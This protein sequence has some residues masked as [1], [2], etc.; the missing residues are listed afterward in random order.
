[1]PCSR[2]RVSRMSNV[3]PSMT[4]ARPVMGSAA[5]AGPAH[6]RTAAVKS[7]IGQPSIRH[8]R[9][10]RVGGQ[11]GSHK[12]SCHRAQPA[13]VCRRAARM[14]HLVA[15]T[16]RLVMGSA[17]YAGRHRIGRATPPTCRTT[18]ARNPGPR[19]TQDRIAILGRATAA[20]AR[21]DRTRP[22]A[23]L[24]PIGTEAASRRC[25]EERGEHPQCEIR[26]TIAEPVNGPSGTCS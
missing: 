2:T 3:S 26:T 8:R 7:R 21:T 5:R 4:L 11:A 22:P 20:P 10:E 12:R 1:M 6:T 19:L 9:Q 24:A 25:R 17:T 23:D 15:T 18:L 16:A 14:I 13:S